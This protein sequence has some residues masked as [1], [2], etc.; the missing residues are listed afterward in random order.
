MMTTTEK[1]FCYWFFCPPQ[2]YKFK[3]QAQVREQ[4]LLFTPSCSLAERNAVL[5]NASALSLQFGTPWHR[6]WTLARRDEP[7]GEVARSRLSHERLLSALQ[8]HSLSKTP[9]SSAVKQTA[10]MLYNTLKK[11]KNPLKE[12]G[13]RKSFSEMAAVFSWPINLQTVHLPCSI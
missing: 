4:K 9:R 6:K 5:Q 11:K 2:Q 13:P 8:N 7:A 3:R 1:K 10:K 12:G